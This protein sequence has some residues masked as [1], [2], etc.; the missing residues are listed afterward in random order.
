MGGKGE[1]E[2]LLPSKPE[3]AAPRS[4]HSL[5]P[6][7]PGRGVGAECVSPAAAGG[8]QPGPRRAGGFVAAMERL[9]SALQTQGAEQDACSWRQLAQVWSQ[10]EDGQVGQ[11]WPV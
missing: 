3:A 2:S 11:G 5:P 1:E 4:Q 10:G 8:H 9:I 6:L 7:G